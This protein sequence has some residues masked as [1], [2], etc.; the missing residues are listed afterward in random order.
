[1]GHREMPPRRPLRATPPAVAAE[2]GLSFDKRPV[3]RLP[4][5]AN[6]HGIWAENP[7]ILGISTAK[8]ERRILM[9]FT[10]K[11]DVDLARFERWNVQPY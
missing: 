4:K 8:I 5:M 10:S 2:N 3:E 1:M 6:K 9:A 7:T 11:M